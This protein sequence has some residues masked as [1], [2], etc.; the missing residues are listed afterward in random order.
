[1]TVPCQD[2]Y[3]SLVEK[4]SYAY[5]FFEKF[6]IQG[7]LKV[8]DDVT[9]IDSDVLDPLYCS[10]DYMGANSDN[11]RYHTFEYRKYF[12]ENQIKEHDIFFVGSFC[13]LSKRAISHIVNKLNLDFRNGDDIAVAVALYDAPWVKRFDTHWFRLGRVHWNTVDE[14]PLCKKEGHGMFITD[15]Y[16]RAIDTTR[17]ERFE[18]DLVD[19]YIREDDIVLELGARYGSVSCVINSKL[20]SKTNQVSV[21][22]DSRVW[23]ALER[24]R[25]AN[26]CCFHTVKG[27]I[28]KRGLDLI[29]LDSYDGYGTTSIESSN[30]K[31][32]SFR[33]Q[34]I[35]EK[36]GLDFNVLVA[37]CEGFLETFFEENPEF[38]DNLRLVIFE[39]DYPDKCDYNKIRYALKVRGFIQTLNGHQ[40]VW[41]KN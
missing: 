15:E 4:M 2:I 25:V 18:Q 1:M 27:F 31:I 24:N 21:E 14:T 33:L 39:A 8:D 7:I 30:T 36:Y 3:Q 5:T 9:Y 10:A 32:P 37:D 29:E 13:W 11:F 28:S 16:D 19:E 20:K 35:R 6:D 12:P 26:N 23:A 41:I 22:P 34:E 38:Y 17:V 40:N